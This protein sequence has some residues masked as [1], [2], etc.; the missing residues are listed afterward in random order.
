MNN[1]VTVVLAA[2]KGVRLGGPKALLLWPGRPGTKPMPLAVAHAEARL[3]AESS[4]VIVVARKPVVQ[5][6]I[7]FVR[8]GLDL[9]VSTAPDDLGPA[10]SIAT[11]AAKIAPT[12]RVL[13]CPVDTLPA[14]AET[15]E[16]LLSSLGAEGA[17]PIATRPRHGARTGHP[18]ALWGSALERYRQPNP[19]PLREYLGEL[20]DGCISVEVDDADVLADIDTPVEAMRYLRGP[21]TFLGLDPEVPQPRKSSPRRP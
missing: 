21:P 16:R 1:V 5:A 2:G 14:R 12:D 17:A 11:A 15:V 7:P 18:V 4:R 8:P 20:G 9:V 10:G 13:V 6:L 19:P 3:A